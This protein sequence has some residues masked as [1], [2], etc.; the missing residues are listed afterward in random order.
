MA[1]DD[2]AREAE[3]LRI[4]GA[5]RGVNEMRRMPRGT[6]TRSQFERALSSLG[7]GLGL[8]EVREAARRADGSR[9][10]WWDFSILS[11]P[12]SESFLS[13]SLFLRFMFCIL[14]CCLFLLHIITL[15]FLQVNHRFISID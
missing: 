9:N 3:T 15:T 11:P 4:C 5:F 10:D 14:A 6:V 7:A 13:I 12:P 8:A 2:P 1:L